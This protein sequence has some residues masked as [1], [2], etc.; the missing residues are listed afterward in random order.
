M[1]FGSCAHESEIRAL[2]ERGQWPHASTPELRAH[3]ANCRGC[4]DLV[5]V[6]QAFHGARATSVNAAKLNAP[7][8]LWWRAQ[9]RRRN[10]AVERM[11][12]PILGAQIFALAIT[13][14]T[15]VG[16]VISQAKHGLRWLSWFG[17][18]QQSN[19][20]HLDSLWSATTMTSMILDWNLMLMI[21]ALAMLALL[22]GVVLYLATEKQ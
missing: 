12:R 10:A 11:S 4:G 5:L 1:T 2:L 20:F 19:G 15:A 9:L 14:L 21:P 3:V 22:G 17:D 7:G 16:L 6:T 18:T 8:V 13:F